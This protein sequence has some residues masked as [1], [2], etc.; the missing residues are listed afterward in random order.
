MSGD[1]E[2]AITRNTLPGAL[3]LLTQR[4]EEGLAPSWAI[5]HFHTVPGGH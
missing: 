5:N 1:N 2:C 3:P 4:G